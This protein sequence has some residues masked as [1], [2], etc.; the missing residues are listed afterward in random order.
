MIPTRQVDTPNVS[1]LR[2]RL[3]SLTLH[4]SEGSAMA[5]LQGA[6]QEARETLQ[7][8]S[9]NPLTVSVSLALCLL[10]ATAAGLALWSAPYLALGGG[11]PPPALALFLAAAALAS[12]PLAGTCAGALL[13]DRL[14]GFKAGRHAAALRA[15][16]GFVAAAA[17][18][19]PLSGRCSSFLARLALVSLWLSA[20]GALLP[21]STGVLMT[22]MPSYLRSFSSASS[23]VAFHLLGFA[24]VPGVVVGLMSCFSRPQEGLVFGVELSFWLTMPAAIVILWAYAREPK[25]LAPAPAGL[26]GVDDLTFADITYELSR[27]RMGTSPL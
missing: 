14:D 6:S 18:C 21:I 25:G 2:A 1:P 4:A 15:A 12:A 5:Y 26:S 16:C 10:H 24:V 17:L 23:A 11:A 7:G 27:R 8:V 20:A 9:R 19:G 3:D 22:S 13:C